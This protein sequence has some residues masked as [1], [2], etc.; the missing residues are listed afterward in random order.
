LQIQYTKKAVA[1]HMLCNCFP[2]VQNLSGNAQFNGVFAFDFVIIADDRHLIKS[3][4]Q[5][6]D[7][8]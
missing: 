6:I 4:T 5:S 1:K 7:L 2:T 8:L 3:G